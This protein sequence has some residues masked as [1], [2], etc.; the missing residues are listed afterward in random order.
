[1]TVN[2]GKDWKRIL[3]TLIGVAGNH[4]NIQWKVLDSLKNGI[5][6]SRK[7]LYIIGFQR[8]C[9]PG[10]LIKPPYPSVRTS[11]HQVTR[12]L[13]HIIPACSHG[14]CAFASASSSNQ[15]FQSWWTMALSLGQRTFPL[16][17][18]S[19]V[20]SI[21]YHQASIPELRRHL[22]PTSMRLVMC[23][24]Q[25]GK[26]VNVALRRR[27]THA[28]STWT[29]ATVAGMISSARASPNPGVLAI[30]LLLSGGVSSRK[31]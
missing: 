12:Q 15:E 11:R 19:R 7:R 13:F 27:R 16:A 9:N 20:C 1:M 18:M 22:P 6:Q 25:R 28:L 24:W 26:C 3:G 2:S 14:V 10:L 21:P 30:G 23:L 31:R 4:Y 29:A 8:Y 17:W 5:P